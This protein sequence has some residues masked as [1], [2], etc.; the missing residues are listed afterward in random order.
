MAEPKIIVET[1][2]EE[3]LQ[4]A[5]EYVERAKVEQVDPVEQQC[6]DGRTESTDLVN[7][8]SKKEVMLRPA[9]AAGWS[10]ILLALGF[11]PEI[12]YQT[13]FDFLQTKKMRYGWHTDDHSKHDN[14][15]ASVMGS[16]ATHRSISL[17]GNHN[18]SFVLINNS[19]QWGILP[20]IEGVSAFV[21]D[22][23]LDEELLTEF[24][25]W[26]NVS[27]YAMVRELN[28]VDVLTV[29]K[30]HDT[31][32]LR[33]LAFNKDVY[34]VDFDEAG[35]PTLS[36]QFQV[37]Q[38]TNDELAIIASEKQQGVTGCGHLQRA[39]NFSTA[40]DVHQDD[41]IELYKIIQTETSA[42]IA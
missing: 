25:E 29:R 17:K 10:L 36:L 38:Y 7:A 6:I 30:M 13:V 16:S 28:L 23:G 8:D 27:K 19:K 32:T 5:T 14:H 15:E 24:V 3:K 2:P 33:L 42:S 31:A 34:Y 39:I 21:Y 40:Y 26:F 20:S 22:Q 9:G 37:E 11:T 18:E 1:T 35:T 41:V 12:A 4:E